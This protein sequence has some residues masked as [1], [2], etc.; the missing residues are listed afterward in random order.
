MDDSDPSPR[1]VVKVDLEKLTQSAGSDLKDHLANLGEL[2]SQVARALKMESF[3]EQLR[4]HL[5]FSTDLFAVGTATA[6][7]RKDIE[8]QK[9]AAQE[10]RDFLRPS[11]THLAFAKL[12]NEQSE[13]H[14]AFS[15][16]IADTQRA[17][18]EAAEQVRRSA[19][20]MSFRPDGF[21][22]GV[23]DSSETLKAFS[24]QIAISMPAD[25]LAAVDSE[26]LRDT[27]RMSSAIEAMGLDA[28]GAVSAAFS[29]FDSESPSLDD[30]S[31]D[32]SAPNA[33]STRSEGR[34]LVWE[35]W[36]SKQPV[37]I[38]IVV[39]FLVQC[40]FVTI[41]Q[42]YGEKKVEQWFF[43]EDPSER[44]ELL[45]EIRDATADRQESLRCV[46]TRT[47]L[48]VRSEPHVQAPVTGDLSP[49][50][51]VEIVE[52]RGAWSL[53]RYATKPSREIREGWAASRFLVRIAC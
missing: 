24:R 30:L 42:A 4:S 25:L 39:Y 9:L 17:H 5:E 44:M 23:L 45:R 38:Q 1:R 53:V 35:E 15:R 43:T 41:W 27:A 37:H 3:T 31:E 22:Q 32:K 6:Q 14:K 2:N 13:S 36:L 18:R 47:K 33:A 29:S 34:A 26:K 28:V 51:T 20:F 10:I 11:E 46:A 49:Q 40:I 16:W 8:R 48:R 21:L 19:E 50:Q 52:S 7:W 12:V